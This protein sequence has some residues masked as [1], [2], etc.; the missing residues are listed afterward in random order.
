MIDQFAEGP[1]STTP[2]EIS[3]LPLFVTAGRSAIY[4]VLYVFCYVEEYEYRLYTTPFTAQFL[5][6][7]GW[8]NL[9]I[10]ANFAQKQT[11]LTDLD[12]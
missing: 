7:V 2:Q 12:N 4:N 10:L 11:P 6:S 9:F 3:C 8:S 1:C 5:V